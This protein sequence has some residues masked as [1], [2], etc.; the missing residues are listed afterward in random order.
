MWE[1]ITENG[2]YIFFW[3]CCGTILHIIYTF[4][5]EVSLKISHLE[6]INEMNGIYMTSMHSKQV[7]KNS[8]AILT[9]DLN[10]E[11]LQSLINDLQ[12]RVAILEINKERR[13]IHPK[14][15]GE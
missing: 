6:N 15:E 10:T 7:Q 2:F 4:F 9:C 8:E 14:R 3:T 13:F 1:F 12:D 5:R 11:R